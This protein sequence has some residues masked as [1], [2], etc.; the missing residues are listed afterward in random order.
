[1]RFELLVERLATGEFFQD[2]CDCDA[3]PHDDRVSMTT[4]LPIISDGSD[5]TKV[6]FIEAAAIRPDW[7]QSPKANRCSGN[8]ALLQYSQPR[9][10][11]PVA[12]MKP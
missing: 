5:T 1:V 9:N 3:C 10:E 12:G 8:Y 11:Q 4:G 7:I 6:W 2:Q